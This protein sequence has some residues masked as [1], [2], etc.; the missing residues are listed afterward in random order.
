MSSSCQQTDCQQAQVLAVAKVSALRNLLLMHCPPTLTGS[1][2]RCHPRAP[3]SVTGRL[4][5]CRHP[6]GH[7][8]H[9]QMQLMKEACAWVL[10]VPR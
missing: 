8:L 1:S 9:V 10:P 2:L 6:R 7:H 4:P 5:H 3:P